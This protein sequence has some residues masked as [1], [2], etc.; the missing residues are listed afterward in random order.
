MYHVSL[1]YMQ[2]QVNRLCRVV[3][4]SFNIVVPFEITIASGI[5]FNTDMTKVLLYKVKLL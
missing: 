2:F 3:S 4:L 5:F 1:Y